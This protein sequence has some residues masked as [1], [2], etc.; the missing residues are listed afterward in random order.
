MSEFLSRFHAGQLEGFVILGAFLTA[1]LIVFLTWQWRL[2]RRTEMEVSLKQE[3]ISRGMSAEDIERVLSAS[4]AGCRRH[5]NRLA[6]S[7]YP[8]RARQ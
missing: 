7:S 2:H 8:A 6:E 3:M 4:M 5:E 1:G